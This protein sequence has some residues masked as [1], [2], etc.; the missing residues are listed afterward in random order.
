MHIDRVQAYLSCQRPHHF[1][2]QRTVYRDP[3]LLKGCARQRQPTPGTGRT[4]PAAPSSWP[5]RASA[6]PAVLPGG[7][8]PHPA[9]RQQQ[10][11]S[12]MSRSPCHGYRLLC[13]LQSNDAVLTPNYILTHNT[14]YY[15]LTDPH[16]SPSHRPN[17][18]ALEHAVLQCARVRERHVPRVGRLVH[19]VQVERCLQLRLPAR[20]EH[21]T[22]AARGAA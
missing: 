1:Q 13:K 6:A 21:D 15:Y 4:C 12:L 2:V 14:A 19:C 10:Q 7:S 17:L 18:P 3:H 11:G 5:L 9:R 8:S 16:T 22:C 20:Q